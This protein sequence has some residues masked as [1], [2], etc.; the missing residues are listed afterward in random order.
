VDFGVPFI[1]QASCTLRA[2]GGSDVL[3]TP[4]PAYYG[5]ITVGKLGSYAHFCRASTFYFDELG[6]FRTGAMPRSQSANQMASSDIV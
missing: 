5:Y 6:S 1:A 3:R 2:A 4:Q